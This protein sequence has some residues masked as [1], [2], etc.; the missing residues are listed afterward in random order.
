MV[1]LSLLAALMVSFISNFSY[2]G[3]VSASDVLSCYLAKVSS[4]AGLQKSDAVLLSCIAQD[5]LDPRDFPNDIFG[6]TKAGRDDR[7]P[8]SSPYIDPVEGF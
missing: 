6:G 2:A 8:I 1:K 4:N 5:S 3:E 7:N